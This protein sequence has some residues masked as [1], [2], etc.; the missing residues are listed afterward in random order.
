M[1][2]SRKNSVSI[3]I[4][5]KN[6]ERNIAECI[7]S[8]LW[9][10]EIFVYDSI[11][12]D[13]T[14]EI[15]KNLGTHVV[16]RSFN[17]FSD[18]KNWAI[19]NLPFKFDWIL[20]LDADER[21][22]PDLQ[23]EICSAINDSNY[24]GYYI[25]RKN[26]FMGK[27]I[28]HGGWFPDYQLRLFRR[29]KARYENRIV[30]EHMLVNGQTGYLRYP[31]IHHDFKGLERYFDRHNTYSSMEAVETS[32]VLNMKMTST[33]IDK[34]LIKGFPHHRRGLKEFA[35][36]FIPCRSLMKFIWMYII[37]L[38]FLDGR[39]GFRFCLLHAFYEYQISL[40]LEEL[41]DSES[42]MYQKY[43]RYLRY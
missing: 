38:G 6:E 40:K 9:S 43:K 22:T 41:K 21:I 27:W 3:L 2:E 28:R 1:D 11:S 33:A 25:P 7:K 13:R 31:I 4:P 39:M 16:Q 18:H 17:N 35:Y 5:T 8:V 42:P 29:G 26:L 37:K 30:H 24:I 34:G 10:G 32:K 23:G 36:R 14:V 15:A 19:E 12:S 20:I